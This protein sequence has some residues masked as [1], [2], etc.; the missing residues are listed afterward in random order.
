MS[1]LSATHDRDSELNFRSETTTLLALSIAQ[2]HMSLTEGD[3][4]INTLSASFQE[5]ANI[6][7]NVEKVA[8]N[9]PTA[10]MTDI[11]DQVGDMSEQINSAIMA[12]QFYDRLCQRMEHVA[13][14]LED[15]SDLLAKDE[16][17]TD[18]EG[19]IHL[20]DTI[21][22]Q[23]TMKE[24]HLM[25]ESIMQGST[26]HEA[27]ELYKKSLLENKKSDDDGDDIELF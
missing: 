1:K 17:F 14:S 4:S 5:L 15:L 9:N 20:R 19:W 27:M 7:L 26:A 21:K 22:K 8:E 3:N 6:C 23:Y 16:R 24:E 10:K 2:I 13:T 18:L 25:F 12:F 11:V